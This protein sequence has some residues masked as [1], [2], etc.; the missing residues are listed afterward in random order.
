MITDLAIHSIF[1]T[2]L[3]F[4]YSCRGIFAKNTILRVLRLS[5]NKLK[6]IDGNAFRGLRLL[7]QLHLNDN[8]I[9][10]VERGT[11]DSISR[12]GTVNLAGNKLTKI[13]YQMFNDL[14]YVEVGFYDFHCIKFL[15]FSIFCTFDNWRKVQFIGYCQSK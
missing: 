11:F 1:K 7:R 3:I 15:H 9:S 2:R 5:N 6:K 14:R 4:L 13:E 12:I 10:Y 8:E